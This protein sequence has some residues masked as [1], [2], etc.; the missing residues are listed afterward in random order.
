MHQIIIVEDDINIREILTFNLDNAGYNVVPFC[1]AEEAFSEISNETDLLI[2]DV[3]LPGIS[4]FQL[5]KNLRQKGNNVPIIFLTAR[6]EEHD[7]LTGF[8]IGGDDYIP[9][10]FSLNEVLA[11][12][13]AVL[14]RT[15]APQ[16]M[17][18]I[19][20]GPLCFNYESGVISLENKELVFSRKEYDLL[21]FLIK[22]PDTYFSRSDLINELWKDAPYV[23]ARTVDVHIARI[24]GKLGKYKDLIK[25]K[26]GFGYYL[27]SQYE[28]QE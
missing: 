15:A 28:T 20:Y 17:G 2:L 6:T 12:V 21:L 16:K 18:E 23:L 26:T 22:H 4:G 8:S 14:K 3:M 5:A 9:K 24:R 10:P 25:N 7:M 27:D 19:I 1:S 11:R 13:K